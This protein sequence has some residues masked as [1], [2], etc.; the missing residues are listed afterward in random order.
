M[1]RF[2][3]AITILSLV[4]LLAGFTESAE[5]A[6]QGDPAALLIDQ[7]HVFL[8]PMEDRVRISAYYILGNRAAEAYIGGPSGQDQDLDRD[9]TVIFPLPEGALNVQPGAGTEDAGRY[10]LMDGAIADTA[11]IPPGAASLEVRF[12]YE[13]SLVEGM[14][15]RLTAP[16]AIIA[17][18]SVDRD[19]PLAIESA[20]VVLMAGP[21]GE[22]QRWQVAGP[23]LLPMGE[24]DVGGGGAASP[25]AQVYRVEGLAAGDA[26]VLRLEA[27]V[28][29]QTSPAG[30]GTALR[31]GGMADGLEL[32][33]GVLVLVVA[34]IMVVAFWGGG[35]RGPKGRITARPDA[36]RE[37]VQALAALDARFEAG[38]LEVGVYEVARRAGK[39]RIRALLG[40]D[41]DRDESKL[42]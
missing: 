30:A 22:G 7:L 21:D 31:S 36:I 5:V 40:V 41:G 17:A 25:R 27:A 24:M 20:V 33:I 15:V 42:G 26:L 6:A 3:Q 23:Q 39:A 16:V 4:L 10:E 29:D 34:G 18:P 37:E 19:V 8:M 38:E 1:R 35:R 2:L 9:V 12:S 28:S 13:L 32:G 11:P 14:S